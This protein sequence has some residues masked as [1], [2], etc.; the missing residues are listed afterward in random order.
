MAISIPIISP[1]TSVHGQLLRYVLVVGL[2]GWL[3]G[4]WIVDGGEEHSLN[5]D[6]HYKINSV[7]GN[8]QSGLEQEQ[9]QKSQEWWPGGGGE[10]ASIQSQR[11]RWPNHNNNSTKPMPRPFRRDLNFAITFDFTVLFVSL[12]SCV[13]V[14]DQWHSLI[15]TPTHKEIQSTN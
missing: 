6:G 8:K 9:E 7:Y 3:V 1:A 14:G 2:E 4:S 12:Y 11:G 5:I 15:P 10:R 13:S